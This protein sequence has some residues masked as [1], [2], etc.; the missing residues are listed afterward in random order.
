MVLWFGYATLGMGCAVTAIFHSVPLPHAWWI[1]I[2]WGPL[3]LGFCRVSRDRVS[4]GPI[5]SAFGP[6]STAVDMPA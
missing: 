2:N 3:S 4:A 5:L 6:I 1:P